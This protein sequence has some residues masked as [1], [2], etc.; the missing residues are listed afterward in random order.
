[1]TSFF[2][3]GIASVMERTPYSAHILHGSQRCHVGQSV[4]RFHSRPRILTEKYPRVRQG[5][6]R[7]EYQHELSGS[8][9]VVNLLLQLVNH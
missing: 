5:N 1:M 8:I 6:Q 2:S 4:P 7:G 9:F 3:E